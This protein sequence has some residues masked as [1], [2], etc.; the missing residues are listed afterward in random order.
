MNSGLMGVAVILTVIAIAGFVVYS[1]DTNAANRLCTSWCGLP[2]Y[3]R[4]LAT[5]NLSFV[6][7]TLGGALG[8][9]SWYETIR[10]RFR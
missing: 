1:V 6:V 9:V 4:A 10:D 5:A 3:G 7:G 8:A 2:E